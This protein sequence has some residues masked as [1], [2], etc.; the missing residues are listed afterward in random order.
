MNI[1]PILAA[2]GLLVSLIAFFMLPSLAVSIALKEGLAGQWLISFIIVEITGAL[3][4][5]AG[6]RGGDRILQ[7]EALVVVS[8][9]WVVVAGMGALPYLLTGAIPGLSNAFF[10]SMSGFTTTGSTILT[11]IESLPKSIL[12]W[13]SMSQWLGGI[14]IIVLFI[15]ILPFF[16]AARQRLYATEIPGVNQDGLTLR[17]KETARAMLKIYLLLSVAECILL[18]AC[19]MHLFDAVCHTFTTVATAGFSTRNQSIGA[20]DSLFIEMIIVVFMI[21]SGCNFTLHYFFL[22]RRW[23]TYWKDV[24]FRV[25]IKTLLTAIVILSL[26]TWMSGATD[27]IGLG[28]RESVFTATAIMTSTGYHTADYNLWPTAARVLIV[29]LMFIGACGGSTGG[30]MK[31]IR[32]VVVFRFVLDRIQK[33]YSPRLVKNVKVGGRV[34]DDSLVQ[35]VLGFFIV[36]FMLIGVFTLI[37]ALLEPGLDLV[38][39]FGAVTSTLNNIGPALGAFGPAENFAVLEASSKWVLSLCMLLGRLEVFSVLVLFAPRFW[40]GV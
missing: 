40:S 20:F 29:G 16:S 15:A 9:G 32:H 21:L 2:L 14:G 25:Y 31:V 3:L 22:D 33:H 13:R 6:K 19:G 28:L 12:L 18:L 10:E 39:C 24:E 34:V 30:G 1:Y 38:S 36:I 11:D 4:W 17:I 26:L 35:P 5:F 8:C 27:T 37:I 7:R 23:K